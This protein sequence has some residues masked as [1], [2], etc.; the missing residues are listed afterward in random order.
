MQE[1][2]FQPRS[3][4]RK[5]MILGFFCVLAGAGVDAGVEEAGVACSARSAEGIERA[6]T[7]RV[8][9]VFLIMRV[10]R[11]EHHRNR[12]VARMGIKCVER[13]S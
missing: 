12:K 5:K 8:R 10:E 9:R 1:R 3:S 2:S 13:M 4:I 6:A 7:A 11:C